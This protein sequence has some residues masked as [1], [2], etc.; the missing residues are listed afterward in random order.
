[1]QLRQLAVN[2]FVLFNALAAPFFFVVMALYLPKGRPDFEPAYVVV[3]SGLAG[4]WSVILFTGGAAVLEERWQGNLEL[5]EAAPAHL[6]VIVAGKMVG[7]LIFSTL[8]TLLCYLVVAW[9]LRYAVTIEAPL[10]FAISCLLALASFWAIGMLMSPLSILWPAVQ[11]F[12]VGLEYPVYILSGFL[13]PIGLLP[14][15][16]IPICAVLPPYWAARALHESTAGADLSV[17][18]VNWI[19]LVGSTTVMA[20][21]AYPLFALVLRRARHDGTL[22][23]A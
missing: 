9:L 5:L 16:L 12:T 22:S 11:R 3:G 21:A 17:M 1:M 13:F 10:A 15:W 8:S 14:S 20:L 6:Y 18:F 2:Y 7:N 4:L 23:Y 19:A